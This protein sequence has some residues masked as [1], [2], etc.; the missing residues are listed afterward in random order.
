MKA[1]TK[2]IILSLVSIGALVGSA[3]LFAD[4]ILTVGIP[5]ANTGACANAVGGVSTNCGSVG[6]VMPSIQ[7]NNYNAFL[8]TSS[9]VSYSLLNSSSSAAP[10][11]YLSP[12]P[13]G[14]VFAADFQYMPPITPA[15]EPGSWILFG[16]GLFGLA[17]T[18]RGR[19][20]QRV[21]VSNRS[22]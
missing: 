17:C 7:G 11:G 14:V 19:V 16:T 13:V 2:T 5:A 20:R 15:P 4:R 8:P 21:F 22:R 1:V 3:P 12:G 10:A 6:S 18:V 9:F